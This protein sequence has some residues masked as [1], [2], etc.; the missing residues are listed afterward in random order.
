MDYFELFGLPKKPAVDGSGLAKK[1]FELQRMHHPDFHTGASELEKEDALEKT[2][3][4]NRGF[5]IFQDEEKTL[6]YFLQSIGLVTADEK[7]DLPPD[8]LMDMMEINE[9]VET[10]DREVVLKQAT[11]YETTLRNEV[12][13]VLN[14]FDPSTTNDTSLQQLKTYH[15]KKKYLKRI[16][17]R[18]RD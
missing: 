2:A 18:L 16:L 13:P 3:A 11:A 1:Y 15:Y 7:F 17:D 6:E 14:S 5:N 12:Q 8:F 10:E 4:I 9:A